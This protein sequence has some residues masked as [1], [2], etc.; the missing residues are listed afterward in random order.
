MRQ[1]KKGKR[2]RETGEKEC[3]TATISEPSPVKKNSKSKGKNPFPLLHYPVTQQQKK[4]RNRKK[5]TNLSKQVATRVRTLA[6]TTTVWKKNMA[7]QRRLLSRYQLLSTSSSSIFEGRTKQ[8]TR[9]SHRPRLKMY[10]LTTVC[11]FRLDLR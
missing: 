10:Q 4:L 2:E 1:R 8:P 11:I 3:K 9:K 7:M 6:K 5:D